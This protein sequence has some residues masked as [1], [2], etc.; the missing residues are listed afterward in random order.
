MDQIPDPFTAGPFAVWEGLFSPDELDAIERHGDG[1]NLQTAALSGAGYDNA[2]RRSRVAWLLRNPQTDALYRKMEDITQRLNRRFFQYQLS[3]LAPM[4]FAVYEAASQSHFEWHNDY[5]RERGHEQQEPRKL[6]LSLQLS[7]P[8][9]Y[10]GG[11]LEG[12]VR[13]ET[14][15]APRTRGAVI[16]FPSYVLHRVTPV[17]RGTRKS[18]V[19][20]VQGPEYR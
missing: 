1:L 9:Q 8:A 16:A 12:R 11:D 10:D 13:K 4:Q 7:D 14:D 18:L 5:G 15:A 17:T 6:S 2:I 20:W 3:G 19:A